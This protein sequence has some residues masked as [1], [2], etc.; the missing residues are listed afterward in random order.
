MADSPDRG[1][2]R[3]N[4]LAI[5]FAVLTI[6]SGIGLVIIT[7]MREGM[8]LYEK[9][10]KISLAVFW[11]ALCVRVAQTLPRSTSTT[12]RPEPPRRED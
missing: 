2:P 12:D 6:P 8:L 7:M 11:V 10:G 1:K 4:C 5:V 3:R 9:I